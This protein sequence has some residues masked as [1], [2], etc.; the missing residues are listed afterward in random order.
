[1]QNRS[2]EREI[3]LQIDK[4]PPEQQRAVL[5]YARALAAEA[6]AAHRDTV[7]CGLRERSTPTTSQ[8]CH[9]RSKRIV[10]R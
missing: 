7:S 5:E 8:L 10:N 3:Q 4:L 6:S 2:I 9:N 1:M